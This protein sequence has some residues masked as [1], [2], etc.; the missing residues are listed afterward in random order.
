M[1]KMNEIV[2][3]NDFYHFKKTAIHLLVEIMTQYEQ[4]SLEHGL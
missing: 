2:P 4:S 3:P 1:P